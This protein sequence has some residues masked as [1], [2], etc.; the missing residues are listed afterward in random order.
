M[1]VFYVS[2]VDICMYN[3]VAHKLCLLQMQFQ[4]VPHIALLAGFVLFCTRRSFI[5]ALRIPFFPCVL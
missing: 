3:N 5:V 1:Y 4:A 2:I